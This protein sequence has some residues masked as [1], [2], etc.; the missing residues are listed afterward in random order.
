MAFAPLLLP[1]I[2]SFLT[3]AGGIAAVASAGIGAV[4]AIS[5]GNYQAAVAK[6]N[7]SLAEQQAQRE[8]AAAQSTAMRLSQENAGRVGELT[9]AQSASGLDVGSR[10]FG[11]ARALETRI[12]AMEVRDTAR[13]GGDAAQASMQ[14]ASNFRAEASNA[15]TQGLLGAAGSALSLGGAFAKSGQGRSLVGPSKLKRRFG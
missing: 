9:A 11:Q 2:G 15:R 6:N 10:S 3:S 1:A 12:G 8:S 14:Q 13:A 5:Q 7:A 4:T